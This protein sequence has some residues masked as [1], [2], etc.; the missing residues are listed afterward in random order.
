MSETVRHTLG[1]IVLFGAMGFAYLWLGIA[2]VAGLWIGVWVAW[3]V[4]GLS[5]GY[6]LGADPV[7][8]SMVQ[9]LMKRL[10]AARAVWPRSR[11]E[12]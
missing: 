12:L 10:T 8:D 2:G 9:A 4:V 6:W 7:A 5:I 3:A 11:D 1:L